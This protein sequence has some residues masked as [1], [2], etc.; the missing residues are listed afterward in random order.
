MK[1]LLLILSV[2]SLQAAPIGNPASPALLQDGLFIPDTVWCQPRASFLEDFL[3]CQKLSGSRH[4]TPVNRIEL[5]GISSLGSVT[6]SIKER[7]DLSFVG[8]SGSKKI[9]FSLSHVP[10]QY[11]FSGG[12]IWYGEAK[13]ILIEVKDTT[14]SAYGEAGGWD[15]MSGPLKVDGEIVSRHADLLMRFWAVG[16]TLSQKLGWFSP[17]SGVI[18]MRSRWKLDHTHIG[19]FYLHQKYPVGPLLGCSFCNTSKILLNLE[20]RG[21]VENA[22]TLSGEIRF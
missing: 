9:H 21:W 7:L 13:L 4:E 8:G 3:T 12:L 22:I 17:Y 19:G 14:L 11:N 16:A 2:W 18:V 6:W 20:W 5:D 1:R 15:W 10:Y